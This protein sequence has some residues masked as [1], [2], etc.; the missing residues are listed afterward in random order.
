VNDE[1]L[2][3]LIRMNLLLIRIAIAWLAVLSVAVAILAAAKFVTL[4]RLGKVMRDVFELLAITKGYVRLAD[5][6]RQ[7]ARTEL[8]AEIGVTVKQE[9]KAGVKEAVAESVSPFP[10][11]D[12]LPAASAPPA[13][14]INKPAE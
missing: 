9:A 1:N 5:L 14:P 8:A 4:R 10:S 7:H 6:T 13:E 2:I 12:G 11:S 3:E